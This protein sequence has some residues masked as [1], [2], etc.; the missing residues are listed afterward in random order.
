MRGAQADQLAR[1]ERNLRAIVDVIN[2][3]ED[4]ERYIPLAR[5]LES[6]IASRLNDQSDLHRYRSMHQAQMSS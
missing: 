6:E 2:S 5:R 4:G 1:L 3:R